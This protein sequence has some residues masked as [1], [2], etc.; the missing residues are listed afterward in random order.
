M[1]Q[2]YFYYFK[3]IVIAKKRNPALKKVANLNSILFGLNEFR[4]GGVSH[5]SLTTIALR[6]FNEKILIVPT[7][8]SL[9]PHGTSMA[10]VYTMES[11]GT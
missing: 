9:Y 3:G 11:W 5:R 2:F 4:T 6:D 7:V 8:T 10:A 1:K